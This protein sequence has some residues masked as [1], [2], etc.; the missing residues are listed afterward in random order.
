MLLFVCRNLK[1]CSVTKQSEPVHFALVTTVYVFG[2]S[3]VGN[4]KSMFFIV[5]YVNKSQVACLLATIVYPC[6][7]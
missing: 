7:C 1:A 6:Y 4:V 5:Q 3:I 2:C